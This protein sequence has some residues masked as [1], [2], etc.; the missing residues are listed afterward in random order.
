MD[1]SFNILFGTDYLHNGRFV[2]MNYSRSGLFAQR[3]IHSM[4]YSRNRL[5]AQRTIHSTNYWRNEYF[6]EWIVR[7]MDYLWDGYTFNEL[8]AQQ[9][10]NT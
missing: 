4:N 2:S 9:I 5:F 7:G 10:N 6:A 3:T 8:F 1:D